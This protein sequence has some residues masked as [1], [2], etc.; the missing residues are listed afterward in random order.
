MG[1]MLRGDGGGTA[2]Y[3]EA[4]ARKYAS[5][6]PT[7]RGLDVSGVLTRI[8]TNRPVVALTFDARGGNASSSAIDQRLI[9]FL[10]LI[11]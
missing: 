6:V 8:R 3:P 2:V 11:N 4:I 5:L 1:E 10:V 9:N 7:Q